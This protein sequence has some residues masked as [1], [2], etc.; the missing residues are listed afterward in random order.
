VEAIGSVSDAAKAHMMPYFP[1]IMSILQPF[2]V[3]DCPEEVQG[4]RIEAIETLAA[5]SRDVGKEYFMPL[6]DDTMNFCLLMLADGPDDPD[7]RRAIYRLI[8]SLSTV[9]NESMATVFPKIMD[10]VMESVISSEDMMPYVSD[11]AEMDPVLDTAN[12]EIDL[13]NTDDEDD[14]EDILAYQTENDYVAEKE[15]AIYALKEFAENTGSAFVPYLQP[16]FENVYKVID[17]PQDEIRKASI[18]A[19]CGFMLALDKMGDAD[20]LARASGIVIP[21]LALL[22]RS[23]DEVSVAIHLLE[24]LSDL[25]RK[26]KQPVI[27]N[28]EHVDL[29]CGAIKDAF[30]NKLACQFNEQSGG[31]DEEDA[32]DS[33]SDEML[34]ETAFNLVPTLKNS[35]QP[36]AFSM[37]FGR[38][39]QFFVQK[40]V[41]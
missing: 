24:Q 10:R 33:E 6:A 31:G 12:V 30:A 22:L 36:E 41:G 16:A 20:G 17:H 11:K 27:T 13:E 18:T 28:Q 14:S 34:I 32:E 1:T 7:V 23:D 21:K 5:L 37:F 38:I 19:I 9:V 39:Y 4:L 8:G 26:A 29:I 25:M 2:L 35:V 3:K 40:L 15:E